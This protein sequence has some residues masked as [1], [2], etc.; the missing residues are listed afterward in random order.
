MKKISMYLKPVTNTPLKEIDKIINETTHAF[1]IYQT[2]SLK[3]R[4]LLLHTLANA[5]QANAK[6]L[7][8]TAH[9]E[10]NLTVD[11]L[12]AELQRTV[13]QLN[14]Y[15]KACT[16]GIFLDATINTANYFNQLPTSDIRKT[17]VPLGIVAVFGASNFPFAYSTPGGDVASALAAG[18]CVIVKAHPAHP[19]TSALVADIF[20][21]KL[22]QL[23]FP[24]GI[25]NHVFGKSFKVGE[26]LVKHPQIKAVGFTGSFTGGKQIFTWANQRQE[27]IPVY[28]E[29]GSTNP[30][31][32][33]PQKLKK[34]LPEIVEKLTSS[35]TQSVGQFCTRPGIIIGIDDEIFKTFITQLTQSISPINAQPMLHKGIASSFKQKIGFNQKQK[36][37]ESIYY[38]IQPKKLLDAKPVLLK[39]TANNFIQNKTLQEEVFGPYTIIVTCKNEQEMLQVAENLAGQLTSTVWATETELNKHQ[40]LLKKLETIAGRIII[41]GVPTG[42][43]VCKAMHH[44][45]TYPATTNS[46]FTAVGSDAIKRFTRPICYQ[47]FPQKNLP[48]ELRNKNVLKIWRTI[49]DKLTKEDI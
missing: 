30:V 7:I 21:K 15:G 1:S 38:P 26:Y 47:N 45:G 31:F 33:L 48:I 34:S 27:P 6:S 17:A 10:T 8:N 35:I 42:V 25:F 20:K 13:F 3:Q 18:C 37:I 41:N 4:S 5:L 12:Q 28:A 29:M 9:K 19:I 14:S 40:Y 36:S 43:T 24:S 22:Q 23:H 44:G 11:R 49:N 32:I 2:Y 46:Q 39:T 16:E